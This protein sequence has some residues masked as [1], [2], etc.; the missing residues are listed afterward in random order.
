MRAKDK[1]LT[2]KLHGVQPFTSQEHSKPKLPLLCKFIAKYR[3]VQF[4]GI[5]IAL[6]WFFD[7][8]GAY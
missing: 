1:W 2:P 3:Y 6:L 8:C 7:F 4:L 5:L